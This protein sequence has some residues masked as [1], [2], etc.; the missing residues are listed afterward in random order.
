MK[1]EEFECPF[2]KGARDQRKSELDRGDGLEGTAGYEEMGCY[3]CDGFAPKCEN[4][5]NLHQLYK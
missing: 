4:R 5:L 2:Y 3:E 1:L